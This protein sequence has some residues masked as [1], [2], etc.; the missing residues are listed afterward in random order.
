M[1][2]HITRRVAACA[3]LA[4]SAL[5]TPGLADSYLAPP[6]EKMIVTPGGVDMRSGRYNYNHTD[7]SIGGDNGLEFTR[8]LRQQE[9]GHIDPFG[10]F[11]HNFD[12]GR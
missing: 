4:T 5:A 3:L 2:A 9:Y 10:S 12:T 1:N 6:P 7:M 8:S 11:S